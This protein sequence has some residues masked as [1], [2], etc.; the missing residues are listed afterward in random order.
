MSGQPNRYAK[1]V[2]NFRNDYMET[3]GLRV[4]LDNMNLQ[5]NKTYKETG[6]LPPQSSMKDNRL[7]SEILMDIEK[8]KLSIIS[9]L[10]DVGSSQMISTVIQRVQ[11]SPYNADG[12]FIQWLAQNAP[13]LA[14]SLKKKF[15]FGIANTPDEAEQLY[16][17]IQS[18][19]TK[20]RDMSTSVKTA[21]DRPA[22]S[23]ALGA[24]YG[25]F[26]KL[27]AQFQDLY[28]N[29][30]VKTQ[31]SSTAE[32]NKYRMEIR[33]RLKGIVIFLEPI[34]K[35][36]N[37]KTNV[38]EPSKFKNLY[39]FIQDLHTTMG[40]DFNISYD[41]TRLNEAGFN[42]FM[43]YTDKLPSTASVRTLL[44]QLKKSD[45]N[46][47]NSLSKQIM[48]NLISILPSSDESKIVWTQIMDLYYA[49]IHNEYTVN[50]NPFGNTPPTQQ[51]LNPTNNTAINEGK[52]SG[53][54]PQIGNP[55]DIKDVFFDKLVNMINVIT[56]GIDTS[57]DS[58]S[59]DDYNKA[60]E[61]A[62]S[63]GLSAV[64]ENMYTINPEWETII[65]YSKPRFERIINQLT[66]GYY[67]EFMQIN[68]AI[69]ID[70]FRQVF[71]T[72]N[73]PSGTGFKKRAGRPKGSGIV[74][75]LRDRID[76]NSG[77]KQGHT[78]VPFCKYILNKN[79]LDDDIFSFKHI[80]GYGVKGYPSKKIS[81]KLSS[82]FKTIVGGGVP[83]F[84]DLST[85]SEEEKNYLHT[86]S[87]KAGIM[88]KF[89][90]PTPSKD[91]LE[92]DIHDFEVMKGEILA[93]NDSSVLIK[94]FKV[95]L[96]KL[97]KNGSLPKREA[98]E[99]MEDLL[100]LGY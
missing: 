20:T 54:I 91:S 3:L 48:E 30:G 87:K 74:K 50:K 58:I 52:N 45:A 61:D 55:E 90:V 59:D 26:P 60:Y 40:G 5:A 28:F 78:H 76:S 81:K 16:L 27:L 38:I 97:S 98:S 22:G 56:D 34:V 13:E 21:F 31:S 39:E 65:S 47:N 77:V 46:T 42:S 72:S 57:D 6:A 88:D 68:P 10:K 83:Q 49:Y 19:Y 93:G 24:S 2:E 100:S 66:N 36:K 51:D 63:D 35:G 64:E 92:K 29:V 37:P 95:L 75:Q 7:T 17:T 84:G 73:T 86:V 89:S 25:D 18:L 15:K 32:I 14:N 70:K 85:L 43:E 96:L 80:K 53:R 33:N 9:D 12:S 69:T 44:D 94:K 71:N 8:L 67:L 62:L 1:D 41:L 11:N 82:I 4:N 99:I 79:R 23:D